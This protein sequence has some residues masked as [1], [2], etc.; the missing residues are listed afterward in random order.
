MA[1]E[2]RAVRERKKKKKKPKQ[3]AVIDQVGCTGCEVCIAF[4]PVDCIEIVPGPVYPMNERLVEVDLHRCIG[5]TLCVKSCPWETIEML[6]YGEAFEVNL[7]W[8]IR[9]VVGPQEPAVEEA[10]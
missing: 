6:P 7:E 2:K 10:A 1:E 4:C 3:L 8:T 9:S 5:C